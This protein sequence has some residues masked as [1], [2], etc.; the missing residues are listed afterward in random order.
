MSKR[1]IYITSQDMDRLRKLLSNTSDPF[2]KDR[3]YLETLLVE[4]DRAKVVAPEGIDADVVTMNST[5]RVRECDSGRTTVFTLVFP[6]RANP[7]TNH[8]SVIAPLGAAL[9]GYRVGDRISFKVPT[10]TRTCEIEA[11]VYQPEAA[12]DLHL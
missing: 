7:E 9:L 8:V 6:E 11:V 1:N 3:P 4:L 5:V 12:G 2:G 10:G